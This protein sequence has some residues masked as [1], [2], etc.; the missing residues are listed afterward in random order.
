M[1]NEYQTAVSIQ[2]YDDFSKLT[3]EIQKLKKEMNGI[4][5][6]IKSIGAAG[7]AMDTFSAKIKNAGLGFK[8]FFSLGK[9]YW[10][11]NYTK[12]LFRNLG[13]IVKKAIDFTE[14]NN[15][16]KNAMGDMYKTAL[17]YQ[18]KMT[19]MYG[20]AMPTM[21]NAQATYKNMLGSIGNLA[22]EIS[23]G[24]SETL[25]KMTLDFSS[26]YN[27][28]FE[29]AATKF[30]AALSKQVRP[31]RSTSGMDITQNVLGATAQKLGITRT[32]SQMNELEKRFLIVIT[33]MDQMA[34]SG[35]MGDF[36]ETIEDPA[37]QIR[38]FKEQLSE[39]GRWVGSIFYGLIDGIMPVL[40]GIVMA[41]KELVKGLATLAG[42][43]INT[44]P[45]NNILDTVTEGVDNTNSG[46]DGAIKK[47]K[48]WKNVLMGFDVANVLPSNS[49]SDSS[50]SGVG[51]TVDPKILDAFNN[52]D[53]IFKDIEMKATT[54]KRTI[55]K[56]WNKPIGDKFK[57]LAKTL[58]NIDVKELGDKLVNFVDGLAR[59]LIDVF[60]EVFKS[61]PDI[62]N[63]ILIAGLK[64][65][66]FVIYVG[67]KLLK[68][69][70][71]LWKEFSKGVKDWLIGIDNY[72]VNS[73]KDLWNKFCSTMGV[74]SIQILNGLANTAK[75]LW[76]KFLK[77]KV[78][79]KISIINSLANTA[80]KLW[81]SF[82]E[83]WNK[84]A[85]KGL[86]IKLKITEIV[87]GVK[88]WFNKTVID[89]LNSYWSK[90]PILG[91]YKIPYLAGGGQVDVGQLF[92]AREAGPELVGTMGGK[93]TVANNDQI[94][95]GI[96][97]AV[98]QA[99]IESN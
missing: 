55:L 1:D 41:I 98:R 10:F 62:A 9:I 12:Q 38:I 76:D 80:S 56:W 29:S 21:M 64:A 48:A 65:V 93:T 63:S 53:Y 15:Y 23:Y 37:N 30:Q 26:L 14:V 69:A 52:Y 83:G 7:S 87:D 11:F 60:V 95:T 34:K 51:M 74:W 70:L 4:K 19:D 33:L 28:D 96:Y 54:I 8:S 24:I 40:N 84:A 61:L 88:S 77:E 81:S 46:L 79:Y 22:D 85:K 13:N 5:D 57:D 2:L 97:R 31:I 17:E 92:I 71:D 66:D 75:F 6:S 45:V 47:T 3:K 72:L 20:L 73:A 99:M 58:K 32:I 94:T 39:L 91:K 42:Y 18:E 89:K 44:T 35:A 50:G 67:L 86:E 59:G 90:V 27:V 82:K 43:K 16:F 25:T 36:A 78:D 49:S 68:T